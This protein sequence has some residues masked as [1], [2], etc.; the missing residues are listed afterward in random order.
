MGAASLAKT[1]FIPAVISLA[2]Y[3]L[4]SFIIVPFFRRYHQRYSQ[5]LPLETI[6]AHTSSLWERIADAIMRRFLPS[7]WRQQ[8]H[9]SDPNDNIS[10]LDEE[11]E[12]MVGMNMDSAQRE[13]LERQRNTVA[14]DEGRLS[15][16]LEE[17]FMDDS[18]EEVNQDNWT[19]R[20]R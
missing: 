2:L 13:A 14:E 1:L 10:I 5:Y 6:T 3:V 4:I 8:A 19:G 7:S 12:I 18:D 11:G 17:G 20:H 9:I 15:R 16:E